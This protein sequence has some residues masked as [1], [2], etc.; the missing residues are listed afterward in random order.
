MPRGLD[1]LA[2]GRRVVA[3]TLVERI[4]SAPLDP[5]AEMVVDDLGRIEGTVTGG[6]VESDLL[7]VAE[8]V[9]AGGAPRVVRYGVSDDDAFEVGLMCGG[10]VSVFVHELRQADRP[11]L[12]AIAR[13]RTAGEPVAV[14]TLMSGAEAGAKLAILP[15]GV[16][17]STGIDLL[18]HNLERE[19]RGLLE[20]GA[21]R[22]RTYG[23]GGEVMG[24]DLSVYVQSFE[25][26][27]EMV[28]CGAIDF[29]IALARIANELG[30]RVTICDARSAFA[31]G[32]RF[33]EVAE[34]VIDWP[35]RELRRR[36]FGSRDAILVFTHDPKFDEPALTAALRSGAGYIGALGSRRTQASRMARLRELGISEKDLGRLSA[37]CGLDLGARTPEETAVSILAE[38]VA[39]RTGRRGGRLAETTGQIHAID[40]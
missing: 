13:A 35:D 24:D 39:E 8:E 12:E 38:I 7:T 5:G 2:D 32:K 29:S 15:G 14:A 23:T 36:E 1:W 37:P 26:P 27:P 9:L 17:G 30:Y 33:S 18:D 11:V 40:R 21:S 10:T 6:C 34:V 20:T 3:A 4:G 16:I 19:A 28:I 25:D 22:I 31:S